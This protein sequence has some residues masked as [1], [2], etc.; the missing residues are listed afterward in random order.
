[1]TEETCWV[2]CY[3]ILSSPYQHCGVLRPWF[4]WSRKPEPPLPQINSRLSNWIHFVVKKIQPTAVYI[5][6]SQSCLVR[7]GVGE[8][9]EKGPVEEARRGNLRCWPAIRRP[10]FLSS[11]R[12]PCKQFLIPGFSRWGWLVSPKGATI[13]PLNTSFTLPRL[14]RTTD[15]ELCAPYS[16]V[17]GLKKGFSIR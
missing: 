9:E 8:L 16:K 15:G 17:H 3:T 1:M 10:F 4:I 11:F 5:W 13:S 2:V 6:Q 12:T 14:P 7:E